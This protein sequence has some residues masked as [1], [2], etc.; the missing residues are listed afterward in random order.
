MFQPE[1][2]PANADSMNINFQE[3]FHRPQLTM[4]S[5]S[6]TVTGKFSAHFGFRGFRGAWTQASQASQ[7]SRIQVSVLFMS[8]ESS[9]KLDVV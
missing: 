9:Q 7:A 5:D 1:I 3:T 8:W 4:G 2:A 6:D